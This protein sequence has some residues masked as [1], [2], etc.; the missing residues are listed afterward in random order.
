MEIINNHFIILLISLSYLFSS[1]VSTSSAPSPFSYEYQDNF[2]SES[3]TSAPRRPAIDFVEPKIIL[4][5]PT[6]PQTVSLLPGNID[7]GLQKICG[8]TDHPI[9]CLTT[10][11]PFLDDKRA[12]ANPISILKVGIEALN[13]KSSEALAKAKQ[14]LLGPSQPKLFAS[15]LQTCIDSYNS[16]LETNQKVL[17]AMSIKDLYQLS[18]ELSCN[19]QSVHSCEDAFAEADID[20]PLEEM[21]A[22]IEKMVS[23]NLAIGVDM[24]HF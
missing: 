19:V 23:N 8:D 22:L 3:P 6:K 11:V 20:S 7:S 14:L 5:K 13:S 17:N 10:T 15:C 18:L 1:S 16:I 4:D 24:V 2:V 9:E 21:N 12:T